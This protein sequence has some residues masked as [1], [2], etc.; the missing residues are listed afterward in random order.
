V[1]ERAIMVHG[2]DGLAQKKALIEEHRIQIDI[3]RFARREVLEK[4]LKLRHIAWP[5]ESR[6]TNLY[7][8][9]GIGDIDQIAICMEEME[10][11]NTHTCYPSLIAHI[12]PSADPEVWLQGKSM[13]LKR[14]V[15]ATRGPILHLVPLSLH[16]QVKKIR[17]SSV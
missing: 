15:R 7:V 8:S 3:E 10:F 11:L 13:A 2:T 1:E 17:K 16:A 12:D 6:M 9:S 14:W 5:H 4:V